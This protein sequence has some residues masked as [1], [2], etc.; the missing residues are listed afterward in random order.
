MHKIFFYTLA[1]TLT[2]PLYAQNPRPELLA[3]EAPRAPAAEDNALTNDQVAALAKAGASDATLVSLIGQ[4][5]TR[6]DTSLEALMA[7]HE[8]GVSN[9]VI[10]AIKKRAAQQAAPERTESKPVTYEDVISLS[11]A[12]LSDAAIIT[13]IERSSSGFDLDA[14]RLLRLKSSGV[15]NSV[16][17]AMQRN[18]SQKTAAGQTAAPTLPHKVSVET[19]TGKPTS[20][21]GSRI[22]RLGIG[23]SGGPY[24]SRTKEF[25]KDMAWE[26]ASLAAG[27]SFRGE[28]GQTGVEGTLYLFGE[29]ATRPD[30]KLGLSLGLGLAEHSWYEVSLLESDASGSVSTT[31]K[32]E[33]ITGIFPAEI[34]FKYS[35][36]NKKGSLFLGMGADYL[37]TNTSITAS[38][39]ASGDYS[40]SVSNFSPFQ[41]SGAAIHAAAGGEYFISPKISL[42]LNLKYLFG[43]K[44]RDLRGTV[45]G[46]KS[47]L[48]MVK[49][50]SNGLEYMDNKP[51]SQGLGANER[52]FEY[53]YSGPRLNAFVKYYFGGRP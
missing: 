26:K 31:G 24:K 29:T 30:W 32:F 40:C 27:E 14:Q 42:G 45:D 21:E 47:R 8:E 51:V 7:L 1:V 3:A 11:K 17:E 50:P 36:E 13:A 38:C 16:I 28:T 5:K 46:V 6:F 10:N 33:N 18:D 19:S 43:G 34:Y 23:Y 44:V 41:A 25:T 2:T 49:D 15:S 53:D 48:I 20:G 22:V 4:S 52:L 35:P 9:A 39:S 12:G 37:R